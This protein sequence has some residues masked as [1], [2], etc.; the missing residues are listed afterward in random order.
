MCTKKRRKKGEAAEA[1]PAMALFFR[2]VAFGHNPALVFAPPDVAEEVDRIH[3]AIE[4]SKTWGEFRQR[5]PAR[6]YAHLYADS[7]SED[8]HA[9]DDDPD[10]APPAD[11]EAFSGECVPGYCEGDYPLW[12]ASVQQ[13]YVPEDLLREH[14]TREDSFLNGSFWRVYSPHR[15]AI[16]GALRARGYEL[17]E[18]ADLNFW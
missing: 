8:P 2:E 10:M 13:R 14:G 1:A 3:R 16:L 5:M 9:I 11:D 18:R 7:F 6:D 17:T 4:Q 15:E 12:I